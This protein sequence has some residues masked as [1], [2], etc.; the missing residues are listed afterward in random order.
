MRRV[1]SLL[2]MLLMI[3]A[4]ISCNQSPKVPSFSIKANIEGATGTV[5]LKKAVGRD[6]VSID[7]TQLVDS[8]FELTD[9][10]S[11][12]GLYLIQM[13]SATLP[14]F[15][16][17]SNIE[18][19][20]NIADSK[21][22]AITGSKTNDVFKKFEKASM[23]FQEKLGNLSVKLREAYYAQDTAAF[24]KYREM[25]YSINEE[26]KTFLINFIESNSSSPV[27]SYLLRGNTY[28]FDYDQID[29]AVN[30]FTGDA[31]TTQDYK[32]VEDY[33]NKLKACQIGMTAPDFTLPDT[34]GNPVALSSLKGKV[35]L[36]DF[37]ASWCSPCRAANPSVV[38][39]YNE[40]KDQGFEVFGVSLDENKENWLQAIKDDKLTWTQ[41]S[42]LKGWKS[43][44]GDLYGVKGIPHTVLIDKDFK[45][46][47]KNLHGE[48]LTEK[49]KELLS[50]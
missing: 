37:W 30:S 39:L 26:F 21:N 44:A 40:F 34:A 48:E 36:L 41:V 19:K 50:K 9:T 38:A 29:K 14:I 5:Y 17:A 23:P 25:Q 20:G 1:N 43:A 15:L 24:K 45:I 4:L 16:D 13:D 11:F 22:I 42:D 28:Q 8:K 49:V 32:F 47:A 3:S 27:A 35:F 6:L 12:P 7:T 2:A 31:K 33:R 10:L 46:V 18:I